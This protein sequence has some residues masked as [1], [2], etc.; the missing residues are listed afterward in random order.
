MGVTLAWIGVLGYSLPWLALRSATLEW[1]GAWPEEVEALEGQPLDLSL[2]LRQLAW[3]PAWLVEVEAEWSWAGR[4]FVTRAT[5]GFLPPRG[6]VP[7]MESLRFACRGHYR[8]TALRLRSGFPLGL[9]EAVREAPVPVLAIRARPAIGHV[10]LP[11]EWTVS[12]D[13]HGDQAQ[14]HAGESLELNMLRRYEPGDAVRRVDWRASGRIGELVVRQFQHPASVL[15][16]LLVQLPETQDVGQPDAPAEHAV[17]VAVA[18]GALLAREGVKALLLLPNA[19]PV[20]AADAMSHALAGALPDSAGWPVHVT[21]AANALRR[22][23]QIL[24][25]IAADAQAA[26]LV[27]AAHRAAAAGARLVVVIATW[28]GCG[29][30]LA[31]RASRLRQKLQAGGVRGWLAWQ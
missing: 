17:R 28:P 29:G 18:A 9:V 11:A 14:G 12:E 25:V 15:V 22:G 16:K 10:S 4:S 1:T 2:R 13:S 27:D 23:E 8:L 30:E 7:V 31:Q 19:A 5:V 24:A 26:P 21:R 3:C 6:S 20:D